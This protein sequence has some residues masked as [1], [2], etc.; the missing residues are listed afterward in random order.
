[1]SGG[2][3]RSPAVHGGEQSLV[4]GDQLI[5]DVVEIVADKMRL[6]AYA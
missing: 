1:M 3:V 2:A 6:R 4:P 5:G